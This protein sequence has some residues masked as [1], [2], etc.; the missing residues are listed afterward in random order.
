MYINIIYSLIYPLLRF[1]ELLRYQFLLSDSQFSK[2]ECAQ[3]PGSLWYFGK[4]I[5]F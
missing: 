4:H 1:I 2:P 3:S 5:Y